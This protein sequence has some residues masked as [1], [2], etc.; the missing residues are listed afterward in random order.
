L[1]LL[2]RVPHLADFNKTNPRL[3]KRLVLSLLKPWR[4]H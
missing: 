2:K 1:L 4:V 3:L